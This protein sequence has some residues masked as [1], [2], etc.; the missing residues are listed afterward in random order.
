MSSGPPAPVRL[1]QMITGYWVSMSLVVAARLGLADLV[2]PG[3][4]TADELAASTGTHAPSLYRLLRAL[5]SVGVF[6]EDETG[7]FSQTELSRLLCSDGP[8][9]KRAFAV[10]NGGEHYRSWAELEYSIRTGETAFDHVYGMPIF[11]WMAGQPEVARNFDRA[12]VGIHGAESAAMCDAYD[13]SAFG[14]LMDVGGGNGSLL[15]LVLQRTPTLQGILY[16]LPHVVERARG[17]LQAAGLAGRCTTVGGDFFASVPPGADAYLMRHIIHDWNDGQ[18]HAILANIRRGIPPHGRLLLVEGVVP[19][20]NGP[21]FT[22]LLDLN[23]L[24]LPGGK[25][26]TEAEYRALYAAAGFRLTRIVPTRTEVSV[27]EGVPA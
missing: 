21:S 6:A 18:A 17:N 2:E 15:T 9:S 12:M 27:L 4:K 10:M 22:K 23:M 19:P 11:D 14:T 13:F 26:R 20:G 16:D 7:R 3:T 1:M 25:E 8:D 24:L 5:A